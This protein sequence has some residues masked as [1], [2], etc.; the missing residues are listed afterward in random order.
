MDVG[1]ARE[2]DDKL[3]KHRAE[4]GNKPKQ[5]PV[6]PESCDRQRRRG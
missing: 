1:V 2:L 5:R 4:A 3:G 6:E